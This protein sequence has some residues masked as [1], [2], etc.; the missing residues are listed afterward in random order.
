MMAR[1]DDLNSRTR[2]APHAFWR[3]Q[4]PSHCPHSSLFVVDAADAIESN[5]IDGAVILT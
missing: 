1:K 4:M 5:L 3:K 2:L